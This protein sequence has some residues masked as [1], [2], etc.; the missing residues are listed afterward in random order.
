MP[1]ATTVAA[2]QTSVFNLPI[3][4][5][6]H[7][8]ALE[9]TV[10][11]LADMTGIRLKLD[12]EVI[13]DLGSGT[14]LDLRNQFDGR[15]AA[16]GVLYI[17]LEREN[18]MTLA[19]RM[20]TVIGTGYKGNPNSKKPLARQPQTLQLEVDLAAGI[21]GT[22]TL[23]LTAIQ[24]EPSPIGV[25]RRLRR[26]SYDV[27]SGRFEIANLP[28][29]GIA[30]AQIN[31]IWIES[32]NITKLEV[33][34]NNFTVFER[35]KALNDVLQADGVR[36]PQAGLYVYDPSETGLGGQALDLTDAHDFR[37]IGEF[38]AAETIDVRVEYLGL[39]Q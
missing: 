30:H 20:A 34:K 1:D 29:G 33:Q 10:A 8:L 35:S 22:P 25:V 6:Y 38:S 12:G 9:Y 21:A 7:G 14:E 19:N 32:S 36:V 31:R 27:P 11:T 5:T 3:G 13:M 2:G 15:A 16:S 39:K 4:R 18:L 26:F 37:L 28:K 24:S 17:N 23:K